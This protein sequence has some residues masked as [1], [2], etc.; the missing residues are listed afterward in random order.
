[1][2]SIISLSVSEYNLREVLFVMKILV[3]LTVLA[4]VILANFHAP[5]KHFTLVTMD[6]SLLGL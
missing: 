1:M 2:M 3:F 6:F 5:V 4:N